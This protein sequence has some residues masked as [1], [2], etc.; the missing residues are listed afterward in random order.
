M[1]QADRGVRSRNHDLY[2]ELIE[3]VRT[4]VQSERHQVN[5]RMFS[6]FFWCFLIPAI[7]S[8]GVLL[9]IKFHI[10][11]HRAR[12]F[13]DWMALIFPIS[14]SLYILSSE[15]LAQVPAVFRRGGTANV[16]GQSLKDTEWRER[17]CEAMK[18]SVHATA[19]DWPWLVATFRIDLSAIQYRTRYLTAL[20][21]AVFFLIMQGI[22]TLGDVTS[23]APAVWSKNPLMG[24]IESS[25]NDF[26]ELVGL[27]L[28]LLLLYLSG[29]QT[30]HSLMRYLH[31]AELNILAGEKKSG[32]RS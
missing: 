24:W 22:D 17:V 20:A 12:G 10:L 29:N 30:Y 14:Y 6:V 25:S 26:S 3:F 13:L 7:A 5:R 19:E 31:C 28:F 16:L 23:E 8:V 32:S 21:G 4:D 1:K 18:R 15:V 11:P 9:L 27:S 2:R